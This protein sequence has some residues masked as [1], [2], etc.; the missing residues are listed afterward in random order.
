MRNI[1]NFDWGWMEDSSSTNLKPLLIKEI[2]EDRIYERF[3]EVEE[4]DIVF[5]AGSSVGPFAYSIVNKN[6]KHIY[7]I[8]PSPVEFPTLNRNL[9]GFPVTTIKKGIGPDNKG[10]F[11]DMVYGESGEDKVFI[12]SISFKTFLKDYGIE[13]IDFL[14]TDCEGGEY[15]IFTD[16]H[17]DFL[18]T[19]PKITGEWHLQTD[20]EKNKFRNFR[21]N[22]LPHFS[23]YEIF[24]VD[25]V[26][27]KWDLWNEHFIEYYR[28]VIVYIDNRK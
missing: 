17:L 18:K 26:D 15:D 21:D 28:Q 13:K 25:G 14:K 20:D 12:E 23:K 5:D 19:V 8:E 1:D 16:E 27:I 6:P 3:F 2:F 22:I 24:S 7:C 11:S 10:F 9:R 4:G